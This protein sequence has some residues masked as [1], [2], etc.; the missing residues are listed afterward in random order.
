MNMI[1]KVSLK[2]ILTF[3]STAIL[4]I[5]TVQSKDKEYLNISFHR[6]LTSH[7]D[8]L[9]PNKKNLLFEKQIPTS[10]SGKEIKIPVIDTIHFNKT[11]STSNNDSSS[12]K[13]L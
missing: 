8:T 1:N 11:D 4:F 13:G 6:F 5:L 3:A 2:T 10:D 9:P 12:F 7:I